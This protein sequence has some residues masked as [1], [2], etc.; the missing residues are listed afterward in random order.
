MNFT[1]K[2]A[3]LFMCKYLSHIVTPAPP[4]SGRFS[5]SGP[6]CPQ[7]WQDSC[8]V[9]LV[10]SIQKAL[11]LLLL[12]QRCAGYFSV[13]CLVVTPHNFRLLVRCPTFARD[14]P[15]GNKVG[16]SLLYRSSARSLVHLKALV[17]IMS[18][19]FYEP[20]H[21][22]DIPSE[23]S[24]PLISFPNIDPPPPPQLDNLSPCSLEGACLTCQS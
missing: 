19:A 16:P 14:E 2:Y 9:T 6:R 8:A 13:C 22:S 20:N 18:I 12:G 17:F 21:A 5:T 3:R 4:L 24:S 23:R 11:E 15:R 7:A 1:I 10:S